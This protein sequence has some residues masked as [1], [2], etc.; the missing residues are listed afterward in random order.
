MFMFNS[1]EKACEERRTG[2]DRTVYCCTCMGNKQHITA[3][4]LLCAKMSRVFERHS[5]DVCL[6]QVVSSKTKASQKR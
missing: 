1:S 4:L 3:E 6:V 5:D 2:F